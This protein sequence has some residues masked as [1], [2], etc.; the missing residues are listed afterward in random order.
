LPKEIDTEA[1]LPR[2]IADASVAYG[3]GPSFYHNRSGKEHMR[4]CYSYVSESQIE[5][6][7]RR[8]GYLLSEILADKEKKE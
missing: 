5:E 7:I 8:L 4:L 6:G 1:L 3:A 2:A